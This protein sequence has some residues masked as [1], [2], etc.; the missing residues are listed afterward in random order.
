MIIKETRQFVKC[1]PEQVT[2]DDVYAA[3]HLLRTEPAWR[4]AALG[5][6]RDGE[7]SGRSFGRGAA[8]RGSRSCMWTPRKRIRGNLL[9]RSK[10]VF[11]NGYR[12]EG[13]P[14]G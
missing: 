3:F 9:R 7:C 2:V 10:P 8:E 12:A 1:G 13:A 14:P 6:S 5:R 4:S 11:N